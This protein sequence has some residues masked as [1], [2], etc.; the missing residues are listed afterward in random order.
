M[1]VVPELLSVSKL[2]EGRHRVPGSS[3][4]LE[5]QPSCPGLLGVAESPE[6]QILSLRHP[7]VGGQA[8][9]LSVP[10]LTRMSGLCSGSGLHLQSEFTSD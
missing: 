9:D 10:S 3:E 7:V 8:L 4:S 6:G 5:G 2:P 1:P